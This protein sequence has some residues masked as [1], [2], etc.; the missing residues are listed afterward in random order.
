MAR[1]RLL[2]LLS[3]V[4][5]LSAAL[6]AVPQAKA[7]KPKSAELLPPG[8][9]LYMRVS[10]S[11]ELKKKFRETTLGRIG[12]EEKM[13]PFIK[14]LYGSAMDSYKRVEEDTGVTLDEM[15]DIPQGE[16]CI[17]LVAPEDERPA[18]IALIEAGDN[19][20]QMQKLMD[21]AKELAREGNGIHSEETV[22]GTKMD[23]Y[24][25]VG[26]RK[27]TFVMFERDGT[28]GV[29]TNLELARQMLNVWNG[30]KAD[31][32]AD[33][34]NFTA[35][36]SRCK[37][38]NDEPAHIAFYIDPIN[39]VKANAR[40]DIL[41]QAQMAIIPVIGL[42]GLKGVGGSVIFAPEKFDTVFH[43]HV[44]L[45]TPR[46]G[47]L[48]MLT[49]QAGDTE[50]EKWV[51][52]DVSTYATI[53]WDAQETVSN[54]E[55]VYDS[56]LGEGALDDQIKSRISD[57]I[58]VD[59][60]KDIINELDGRFTY[61]T[62]LEPPARVDSQATLLAAKLKDE[63]DFRT[64]A[65]AIRKNFANGLTEDSYAGVKYYTF[66]ARGPRA[67]RRP[68][69]ER[70]EAQED[71]EQQPEQQRPRFDRRERKGCICIF[72]GYM[73][74]CDSPKLLGKIIETR[75]NADLSLRKN[76]DYKVFASKAKRQTGGDKAGMLLFHRPST[77]MKLMYDLAKEQNTRDVLAD[78]SER[79]RVVGAL[80]KALGE[81][82]LPPFAE[83]SKHLTPT[84]GVLVNEDTGF[85]FTGF[86]LKTEGGEEDE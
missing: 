14:N 71:G 21:R 3:A 58:G 59:F 15:L 42:D 28:V 16:A 75:G 53:H 70:P 48:E 55:L 26:N 74:M 86:T 33:N 20:K 36:M 64:V 7:A 69:A 23:I 44:A 57:R 50:P 41:Q 5:L 10:D 84:G 52:K 13:Q 39:L 67:R 22:A 19:M 60:Q 62:W 76:I 12:A 47:V 73:I 6:C 25:G 31:T 68:Q 40:G 56:F 77:N 81:T 79:N 83:I 2:C 37:G 24:T 65:E 66:E 80:N 51:P 8:T 49:L 29:V 4:T 46:T 85:H 9:L 30:A 61:M 11:R 38:S 78:R 54:L 35:I 45:D 18:L 82:E 32:L 34:K 43:L 27:R 1:P 63:K 72:D 17:A